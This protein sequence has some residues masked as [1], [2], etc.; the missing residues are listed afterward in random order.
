M[1]ESVQ[2]PILRRVE[3]K[4]SDERITEAV[5]LDVLDLALEHFGCVVGTIHRLNRANGLL[6]IA[7]QRGIPDAIMGRVRIIPIGKGMAGLAAERREPVQVCNLQTDESG[8]AKPG[9]KL[10]EMEGSIAAPVLVGDSLRGTIGVAKPQAY[11]FTKDEQALLLEIGS[12]IGR[13]LDE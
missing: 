1:N 11:E 5:L 8:V 13:R 6:E 4:L 12:M 9:A 7:A 3:D 2:P 10:T